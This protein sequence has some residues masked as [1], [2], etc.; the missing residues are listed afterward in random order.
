MKNMLKAAAFLLVG[1]ILIG[2]VS[3]VLNGKWTEANKETYTSKEFYELEKN[4]V[5]VVF[6]GSSQVVMGISP[7][8]MYEKYGI[9]AYGLG[10]GSAPIAANYYWLKECEK[11]QDISTVVIDV[12]M[13]YEHTGQ[14]LFRR[15]FDPMKLSRN[16]LEAVTEQYR[17]HGG[18]SVLTY[19]FPVMKYHNRWKE[20]TKTDFVYRKEDTLVYGGY[21]MKS[22]IKPM[23]YEKVAIDNDE[24]QDV[25]MVEPQLAYF[26][27]ILSHCK[28]KGW[29]VLLIKTPKATWSLS[30]SKG[31]EALAEKHG[32]PYLDFNY[33]KMLQEIKFDSSRD[34]RDSEHMNLRGAEKLSDYIGAYLKEHYDL[35]DH[36]QDGVDPVDMQ[37]YAEDREDCYLKL[38]TEIGE[39]L[40]HLDNDRYGVM[41][42]LTDNISEGW[43]DIYQEKFAE[44]GFKTDISKLSG[45]NYIGILEH[46]N[47]VY[48]EAADRGLS[49]TGSFEGRLPY[50]VWGDIWFQEE[51]VRMEVSG[52]TVPFGDKGMNILVYD[53]AKERILSEVTIKK[54]GDSANLELER[55]YYFE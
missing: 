36:R 51:D 15:S 29:N 10:R 16:K 32:L 3:Q 53:I 18:D 42:Q 8:R 45:K 40:G 47:C 44:L 25:K 33:D 55:Q 1:A 34:M 50:T 6:L 39:Y 23:S 19:V 2:W 20:L 35:K 30:K 38:S 37:M 7:V 26:E 41:V 11:T 13:L 9:A 46:G 27:R 21:V 43:R 17:T 48:E 14:G 12:S 49:Y 52:T 28:E 5:D 54:Q 22:G 24:L 4:S 31:A